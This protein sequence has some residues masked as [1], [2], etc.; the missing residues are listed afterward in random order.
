M[1]AGVTLNPRTC[2]VSTS[3]A[4]IAEISGLVGLEFPNWKSLSIQN[5]IV[6]Y[7]IFL[8]WGFPKR[9]VELFSMTLPRDSFL[10]PQ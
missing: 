1:D 10:V 8:A 9:R 4:L 3:G 5:V 7:F 2:T 6:L